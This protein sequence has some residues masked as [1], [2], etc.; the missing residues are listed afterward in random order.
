MERQGAAITTHDVRYSIRMIAE[1]QLDALHRMYADT[2][3][4]TRRGRQVKAKRWGSGIILTLSA[5][6]RLP[7]A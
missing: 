6:M 7:L 5:A 1:A 2:I 3:I 4:V